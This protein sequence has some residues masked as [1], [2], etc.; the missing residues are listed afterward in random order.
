MRECWPHF[1]IGSRLSFYLATLNAR[2]Y[3]FINYEITQSRVW[4]KREGERMCVCV[5]GAC[6]PQFYL[7]VPCILPLPF[8]GEHA[9][10]ESI[11]YASY[12]ASFLSPP[13]T[14]YSLP[15]HLPTS[16]S[17][18]YA[19]VRTLSLS[20]F[21]RVIYNGNLLD[22]KKVRGRRARDQDVRTDLMTR[23]VICSGML[24]CSAHG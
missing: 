21:L 8:T 16:I 5:C 11:R 2:L 1:F 19:H 18:T 14:P 22:T 9:Y 17:Y 13:P 4:V 15:F 7:L 23:R 24:A 3:D 10:I 6:Q 12:A 20:F